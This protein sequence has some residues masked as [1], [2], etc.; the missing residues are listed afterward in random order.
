VSDFQ[1]KRLYDPWPCVICGTMVDF[2][3]LVC[4][5][6]ECREKARLAEEEAYELRNTVDMERE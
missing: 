3:A 5:N 4:E 2:P 1:I 6:E